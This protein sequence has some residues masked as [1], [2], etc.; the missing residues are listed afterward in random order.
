MESL[1]PTAPGERVENF[2]AAGRRVIGARHK[3]GLAVLAKHIACWAGGSVKITKD[4]PGDLV[5]RVRAEA[6]VASIRFGF[7]H[8]LAR[9]GGM[10]RPERFMLQGLQLLV[11]LC[12]G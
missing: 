4:P 12:W 1:R 8:Q 9:T 3:V 2:A 5:I 10:D 7:L 11:I 6:Q